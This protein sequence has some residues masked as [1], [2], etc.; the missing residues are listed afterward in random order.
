MAAMPAT[1]SRAV[2]DS[3]ATARRRPPA[4]VRVAVGW[5]TAPRPA[6]E[7]VGADAMDRDG[8][9]L[10]EAARACL[11]FTGVTAG[12][13]GSALRAASNDG[14]SRMGVTDAVRAVAPLG[15]A[16]SHRGT[17]AP[18]SLVVAPV[19][20]ASRAD[21]RNASAKAATEG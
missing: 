4:R 3:P 2:A 5:P 9:S 17:A 13:V 12:D 7:T 11:S 1:S 16:L 14:P 8:R 20:P 21:V 6:S 19:M 18:T 10:D 15:R